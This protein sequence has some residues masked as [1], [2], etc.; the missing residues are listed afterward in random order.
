MKPIQK[1][2]SF[3]FVIFLVLN[4]NL[5]NALKKNAFLKTNNRLL[6]ESDSTNEEDSESEGGESESESESESENESES[7][8][9]ET[10]ETTST[11]NNSNF[12]SNSTIPIQSSSSGLSTGAICAIAI[13]CIA[14]LLGAAAAAALCKGGA[15]SIPALTPPTPLQPNFIDTSLAKFNVTQEIPTQPVEIIQPQPVQFE[16]IQPQ[17]VQQIIRPTYPIRKPEPP[18]INKA[19]QPM[20]LQAQ[21]Q[22]VPVQQVE[23]VPVQ[24][25]EMVPVKEIVPLQQAIP[26]QQVVPQAVQVVPMQQ[27]VGT[28]PGAQQIGVDLVGQQQIVQQVVPQAFQEQAVGMIPGV[29]QIGVDLVGQQQIIGKGVQQIG[30]GLQGQIIENNNIGNFNYSLTNLMP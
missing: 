14:G 5:C 16:P 28:I 1:T 21:M 13:P 6:D 29:Q 25:V 20:H 17:P 3:L 23:M 7:I 10:T 12:N 22:M 9:L 8:E 18:V 26:V 11:Y 4:I 24:Q 2:I 15:A 30:Q 19:F 27:A